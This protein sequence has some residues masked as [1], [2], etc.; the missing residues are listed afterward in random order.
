MNTS[1]LEFQSDTWNLS[2]TSL[3]MTHKEIPSSSYEQEDKV[4][5]MI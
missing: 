1:S 3:N 5:C 4:M 2:S